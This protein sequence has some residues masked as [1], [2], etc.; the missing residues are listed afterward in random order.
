[1]LLRALLPLHVHG[2][3]GAPHEARRRRG[4]AQDLPEEEAVR[5]NRWQQ[6]RRADDHS[7]SQGGGRRGG[8]GAAEAAGHCAERADPPGGVQRLVDDEGLHRLPHRGERGRQEPQGEVR[9]QDCTDAQSRRCYQRQLPNRACRQRPQPQMAQPL[10]GP[11]PH[12][13]P[14]EGYDG[15]H[16]RRAGGGAFPR[17]SRALC[18]EQHLHLWVRPHV[19]G[20]WQRREPPITGGSKTDALETVPCTA[21]RGVSHV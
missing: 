3:A 15:P 4:D 7:A 6:V 2:P 16:A 14:H 9:L 20:Q 1:M 13:L 12:H 10:A 17:L 18:Q 19:L 11:P 8:S 21:G 5:D